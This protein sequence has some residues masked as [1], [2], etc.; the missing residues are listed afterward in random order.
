MPRQPNR[1]RTNGGGAE[2]PWSLKMARAG[3]HIEHLRGLVAAYLGSGAYRLVSERDENE[4]RLRLQIDRQPPSNWS[5]IIGDVLHNLRSALDSRVVAVAGDFVG[6]DLTDDEERSLALPITARR[7]DF[8]NVTRPWTGAVGEQHA[9]TLRRVVLHLQPFGDPSPWR[10]RHLG[11]V[12]DDAQAAGPHRHLTRRLARL[13]RLSNIDKH[14]RVHVT[15]LAPGTVAAFGDV[16]GRLWW[17]GP[18][19]MHDGAVMARVMVPAG[20]TF[21]DLTGNLR[22]GL[23][24]TPAP[25]GLAAEPGQPALPRRTGTRR[26]R[27]RGGATLTLRSGR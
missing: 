2:A 27:A 4:S 21:G 11:I 7:R 3:E 25:L 18:G 16:P 17:V 6:R 9:E 24:D 5:P 15:V 10:G 13:G 26:H 23:D 14:R 22:G 19:P 8:L 20:Y 1:V 12:D